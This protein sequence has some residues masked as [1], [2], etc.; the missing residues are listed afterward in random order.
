MWTM[1]KY[2]LLI[3]ILI[4]IV[5]ALVL[6]LPKHVEE[7]DSET[8]VAVVYE[9][10][11]KYSSIQVTED[12]PEIRYK[13]QEAMLTKGEISSYILGKEKENLIYQINDIILWKAIEKS[14]LIVTQEE[15]NEHIDKI[16]ASMTDSVLNEQYETCKLI[17]EALKEAFKH[18]ERTDEIY[19]KK[20]K[21]H[22]INYY[23][24][25]DVLKKF[26][27]VEDV[28]KFEE[29]LD[30]ALSKKFIREFYIKQTEGFKK[31]L[32]KDKFYEHLVRDISVSDSEVVTLYK[33][34]YK[35]GR[36][37]FDDVK[38]NLCREIFR[39]KK[40]KRLKEWWY[41]QLKKANISIK[42]A[43]FKNIM[44]EWIERA[45]YVGS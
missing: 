38:E 33:T 27:T 36:I 44:L 19:E 17:A 3:F 7:L 21:T 11:I 1:R 9:Q 14:N 26:N 29:N 18:P 41:V 4:I 28:N 5:I 20:L 13:I 16:M 45:V 32:L 31:T 25:Q 37:T 39:E 23:A 15:I 6:L 42:V 24:W 35:S 43:R 10:K 40:E 30:E 2:L 12:H 22:N 8:V 34:R